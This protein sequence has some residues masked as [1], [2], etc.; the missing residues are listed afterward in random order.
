MSLPQGA[1]WPK[2]LGEDIIWTYCFFL[3]GPVFERT[4]A[5]TRCHLGV[6]AERASGQSVAAFGQ[7]R[8]PTVAKRS[9]S[10]QQPKGLA[11][12]T[13]T[14]MTP[15]RPWLQRGPHGVGSD[16]PRQQL[17]G[18]QLH[19]RQP[20]WPV[21]LGWMLG[22]GLVSV[23]VLGLELEA[24]ARQDQN[25]PPKSSKKSALKK[26]SQDDLPFADQVLWTFAV[27]TERLG[28]GSVV[29]PPSDMVTVQMTAKGDAQSKVKTFHLGPSGDPESLVMALEA[30][31]L[32]LVKL[33]K[34]KETLQVKRFYLIKFPL[35]AGDSWT[36]KLE[37]AGQVWSAKFRVGQAQ[38]LEVPAG[39]FQTLPVRATISKPPGQPSGP[40]E[41]TVF[42]APQQGIVRL[43]FLRSL[44]RSS[45]KIS[46]NLKKF[47]KTQTE[48]PQQEQPQQEQP[49][50]E[51]PQQDQPH[52]DQPQPAD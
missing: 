3:L 41:V 32:R 44:G 21:G 13:G 50:Q 40:D 9:A 22:M 15:S 24:V 20:T 30:N 29:R 2:I 52:Q 1:E 16:G 48:Q 42:L 49:Q 31:G 28:E 6:D 45:S 5:T 17:H 18:R 19:G 43:E 27:E 35:V 8:S 23:G 39:T 12:T 38:E 25:Q 7:T 26:I 14:R 37:Q 46:L 34:F 4:K 36:S 10:H 47:Q 51:Q 11:M 33:P